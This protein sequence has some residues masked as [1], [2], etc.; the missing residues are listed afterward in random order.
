M[1]LCAVSSLYTKKIEPMVTIKN[2]SALDD[3]SVVLMLQDD[4][5]D[6]T[7]SIFD[8]YNAG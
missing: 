3:S 4:E 6:G 5:S 1:E 8:K 2:D 7:L